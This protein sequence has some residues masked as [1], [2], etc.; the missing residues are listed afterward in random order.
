M[1]ILN[2]LISA[3]QAVCEETGENSIVINEDNLLSA[4]SVQQWYENDCLLASALI[5]SISIAHGFQNGNKRTAACVGM[6]IKDFEC[7]ESDMIDCIL[8]V[9]TGKIKDVDKIASILYPESYND[10]YGGHT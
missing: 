7:S 10:F 5:R 2:D 4:L 9:T 1:I 6:R 8:D 3:N